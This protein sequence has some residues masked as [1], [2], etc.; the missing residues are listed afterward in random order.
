MFPFENGEN[1]ASNY[2]FRKCIGLKVKPRK[3]DG[4]LFYS[5]YPNGTIDPVSYLWLPESVE[6]F[7]MG[8]INRAANEP[9]EHEQ[10]LVRV[11]LLRNIY[12]REPFTNTYRT[13]FYVRVRL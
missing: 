10:D 7:F 13:R 9:N 1:T 4:L 8:S 11:R 3:G 12:V 6:L 2:D 5:L